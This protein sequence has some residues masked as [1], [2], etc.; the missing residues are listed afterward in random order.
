MQTRPITIGIT[1]STGAGKTYTSDKLL[2]ELGPENCVVISIDDFYIKSDEPL[3]ARSQKNYDDPKMIE[4]SLLAETIKQLVASKSIQCPQYDFAIHN[5]TEKTIEIQP[6]PYIIIEG[7][8]AL[9]FVDV[10]KHLDVT[11]FIETDPE[12]CKARRIQRDTT[13]RGRSLEDVLWR[14]EHHIEPADLEYVRPS[15]QN[16]DVVLSNN[17][18]S[19]LDITQLVKR[20]KQVR[21]LLMFSAPGSYLDYIENR[22]VTL[23]GDKKPQNGS[24]HLQPEAAASPQ[25]SATQPPPML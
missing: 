21:S 12:L 23:F 15:K 5:R 14:Y 25:P 19:N 18:D 16:A 6:K 11:C 7:I 20:I 17:A 8:F 10:I 24:A 2:K 1:G 9:C 3:E 22:P 13:E 4:S